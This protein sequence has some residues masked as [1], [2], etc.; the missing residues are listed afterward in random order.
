MAKISSGYIKYEEQ[1]SGQIDVMEGVELMDIERTKITTLQQVC[2][3]INST[4]GISVLSLPR[5]G[6]DSAGTGGMLATGMALIFYLILIL[7]LTLLVRHYP[8]QCLTDFSSALIGKTLG[9]AFSVVLSVVFILL[10]STVTREFGEVMTITLLRNTPI[11]ITILV[12]LVTVALSSTKELSEYGFV[13]FYYL[14]FIV[15]PGL[16]LIALS[17]PDAETIRLLPVLGNNT[18]FNNILSGSLNIIALP[19]FQIG[20]Y[21]LILTIPN[22]LDPKKALKGSVFGWI[23]VFIMIMSITLVVFAVF[24]SELIK[25][26]VWPVLSLAKTISIP[27][28]PFQRLDLFFIVF[29]VI[30]GFTTIYS[31]YMISIH[32]FAQVLN[33][34]HY[35]LS[36]WFLPLIFILSIIPKNHLELYNFMLSVGKY[37]LIIT[38]GF[39][40][41][42][43]LLSLLKKIKR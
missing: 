23:G 29:W 11:T 3:L 10:T 26:E 21:T 13:N 28:P 36:Y 24:G 5:W 16:V 14:P 35:K 42:L 38:V 39:P 25:N 7:L 18:S 22:M 43:V 6:A 2:I 8:G 15:I 33:V 37:S 30:T 4:I 9:K 12:L 19:F 40:L 17:I 20:L 41:L 1:T 34:K 27:I 31:G 32:T